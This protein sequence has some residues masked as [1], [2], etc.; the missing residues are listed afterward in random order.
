MLLPVINTI[1]LLNSGE[2][3]M[4]EDIGVSQEAELESSE[5]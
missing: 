3:E 1:L 5:V 2:N 4:D